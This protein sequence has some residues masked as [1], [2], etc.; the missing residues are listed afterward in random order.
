[1]AQQFNSL[2]NFNVPLETKGI[3]SKDWFFYWANLFS[4]LPPGNET[5]LTVGASPF[6]Y[7][8]GVKGSVIVS[9]GTVSA[10]EFSRDGTTFYN[11]G[12]TAGMFVLNARD[13]LRVTYTVLPTMTFVPS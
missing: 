2:P 10:I 7:V 12:Q 6:T 9:G 4:G 8:A 3:T 1:M 13:S 5:A 11:T